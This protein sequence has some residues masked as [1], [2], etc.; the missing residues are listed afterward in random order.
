[1]CGQGKPPGKELQVPAGGRG[2]HHGDAQGRGAVGGA[3]VGGL[4]RCL[5]PVT[6][7]DAETQWLSKLP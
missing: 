6:D 2:P 5:P 3:L 4:L 7:E 1:M